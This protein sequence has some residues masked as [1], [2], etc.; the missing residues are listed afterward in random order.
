[1]TMLYGYKL[2]AEAAQNSQAIERTVEK[3]CAKADIDPATAV[4]ITLERKP[5]EWIE[6]ALYCDFTEDKPFKQIFR[7]CLRKFAHRATGGW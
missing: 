6:T 5:G 3:L 1:M 2:S 4:I 7:G